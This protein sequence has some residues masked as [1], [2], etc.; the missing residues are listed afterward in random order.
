MA[1]EKLI[2][3]MV[4]LA[5]RLDK[6]EADMIELQGFVGYIQQEKHDKKKRDEEDDNEEKIRNIKYE[7]MK[8]RISDL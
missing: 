2:D 6:V 3:L 8:D 5:K 1:D 7:T 4:K